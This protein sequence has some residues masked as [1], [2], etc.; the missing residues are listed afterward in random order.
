MPQAAGRYW[1]LVMTVPAASEE[2]ASAW[3]FSQGASGT[4][5][6]DSGPLVEVRGY[7]PEQAELGRLNRAAAAFLASLPA[8]GLPAQGAH[9]RIRLVQAEDWA[10][11]WK[12]YYRPLQVGRVHIFPSWL[13]VP[14]DLQ[15]RAGEPDGPVI[16]RL[17]PGMAFGTGQHPSTV[18]T[19]EL[20]QAY[21]RPG[22]ALLDLGTGSGILALAALGLGAAAVLA[23]DRDP[24]AVEAARQNAGSLRDGGSKIRVEQGDILDP[25]WQPRGGPFDLVAANIL[26]EVLIP[27]APRLPGW[28]KPGGVFIGGGVVSWQQVSVVEALRQAGLVKIGGKA[29]EA[30]VSLA[31][32][33]A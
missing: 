30:W 20:L 12:R 3:L 21:L 5:V 26:A 11:S 19:L 9:S 14:E 15:A 10:E 33:R 31:F 29:Q 18:L 24:V 8:W 16:L 23:V 22:Y 2:A 27:L 25:R 6:Q 7:F 28:L 17:D 32:R 13:P 1:E 4:V